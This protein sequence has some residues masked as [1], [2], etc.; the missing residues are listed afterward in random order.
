MGPTLVRQ[1]DNG[2]PGDRR[3]SPPLV[4]PFLL[5]KARQAISSGK[6]SSRSADRI[7]GGPGTGV[8]FSKPEKEIFRLHHLCFAAWAMARIDGTTGRPAV[9]A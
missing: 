6:L 8:V 7:V 2:R 4:T 9:T 5:E 3:T 1:I